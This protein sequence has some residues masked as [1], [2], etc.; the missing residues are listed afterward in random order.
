MVVRCY[1]IQANRLVNCHH[2]IITG[3]TDTAKTPFGD[4]YSNDPVG[5]LEHLG[6]TGGIHG[7]NRY[8]YANNNPYKYVDPD[9]KVPVAP[10]VVAGARACVSNTACREAVVSGARATAR[11]AKRAYNAIVGAFSE[12][13]DKASGTGQDD[14]RKDTAEGGNTGTHSSMKTEGNPKT[15]DV[16]RPNQRP[17]K[18]R[19]QK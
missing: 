16:N 4:T 9:G 7:F 15:L 12:S 13:S 14:G 3:A 18:Y 5:T 2:L 17:K 19:E 11:G 8:A 1:I 6:G 10:L